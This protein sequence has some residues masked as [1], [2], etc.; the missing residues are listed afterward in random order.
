MAVRCGGDT[1]V[2]EQ[3][4]E[5]QDFEAELTRLRLR[6][7]DFDLYVRRAGLGGSN[8]DWAINYAVRVTHAPTA[9]SIIYWGGAHEDW[10]AEFAMDA[11]RGLYFAHESIT[12]NHLARRLSPRSTLVELNKS[13]P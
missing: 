6:H 12:E 3:L 4:G 5:K 9:K 7:E 1:W 11:R 2:M 8:R 13:S 10:V